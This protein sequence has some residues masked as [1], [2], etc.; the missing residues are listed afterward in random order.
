[1]GGNPYLKLFSDDILKEIQRYLNTWDT[2][3]VSWNVSLYPEQNAV[4]INGGHKGTVIATTSFR[5]GVH[6]W[7][8]SVSDMRTICVGVCELPR[9]ARSLGDKWLGEMGYAICT[10]THSGCT[11]FLVC[12]CITYTYIHTYLHSYIHRMCVGSSQQSCAPNMVCVV[13]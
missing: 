13:T 11:A 2:R 7:E 5:K 12:V 9:N 1:M 10:S 3:F 6:Y 4:D 8:M